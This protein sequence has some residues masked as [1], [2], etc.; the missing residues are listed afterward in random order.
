MYT[1]GILWNPLKLGYEFVFINT[2]NGQRK[3]DTEKYIGS[4][5]R[6]VLHFIYLCIRYIGQEEPPL[7]NLF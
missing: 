6:F 5:S 4:N 2:E 3:A 1:Y 7:Q